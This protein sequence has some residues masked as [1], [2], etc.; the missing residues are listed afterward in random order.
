MIR[1]GMPGSYF[2]K[3]SRIKKV[4]L[5]SLASVLLQLGGFLYLIDQN[6][7]ERPQLDFL[8]IM[9]VNGAISYLALILVAV[10]NVAPVGLFGRL[11][12]LFWKTCLVS[13]F[14]LLG[15]GSIPILVYIISMLKGPVTCYF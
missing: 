12:E 9:G 7:Y 1:G 11:Q 14:S 4:P 2:M 6:G 13:F 8:V 15:L 10:G 3:I 5:F